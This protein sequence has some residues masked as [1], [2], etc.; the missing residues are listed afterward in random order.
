MLIP[1]KAHR[2]GRRGAATVE[3]ALVL[4][5]AL[6]LLFG[7]F[8]YAQVLMTIE[9]MSA[10]GDRGVRVAAVNTQSLA[11]SD[12]R[13]AVLGILKSPRLTNVTIQVY[14]S[15]GTGNPSASIPTWN[16]TPF[17]TDIVVQVDGDFPALLPGFGILP[18]PIHLRTKSFA[19][20]EAN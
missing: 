5:L 18:N 4:S 16:D 11:T 1:V 9:M 20:S 7:V 17:G 19:C 10:G 6:S 15:D 14:A 2:R 12:I 8:E 3:L 13:N